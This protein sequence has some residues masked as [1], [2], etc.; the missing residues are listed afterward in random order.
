MLGLAASVANGRGLQLPGRLLEPRPSDGETAR[1]TLGE[2]RDAGG[3]WGVV[4]PDEPSAYLSPVYPVV[5][6]GLIRVFGQQW[7]SP[8]VVFHAILGAATCLLVVRLGRWLVRTPVALAVGWVAAFYPLLVYQS[9]DMWDHCLFTFLLALWV[10]AFF[11]AFWNGG[12][13]RWLTVGALGG[14][15]FLVRP[16]ALPVLVLMLAW[17]WGCG[18]GRRAAS[19]CAVL[20]GFGVAVSPWVLRNW[21][22]M[23][24]PLLFPTKGGRNLWEFN[25]ARF[26]TYFEW[27]EPPKTRQRYRPLRDKYLPTLKRT[28]LVEFPTFTT[29]G[30]IERDAVLQG[31]VK[32]FL[33]ANPRAY[34][35]LCWLRVG[36]FF[37]VVPLHARDTL[38]RVGVAVP[39][40]LALVLGAVG[41]LA[42]A[43]GG[44]LQARF[45]VCLVSLYAA[46]HIFTAAGI[47]Y[48]VPT[49]PYLLLLA[50]YGLSHFGLR[51]QGVV[52][53]TSTGDE[54]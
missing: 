43:R 5:I 7:L 48:R 49:E 2:W 25:N 33:L 32:D 46:V 20:I 47:T 27:S 37:R 13:R 52:A 6:A 35:E 21:H 38:Q 28:D 11:A 18:A 29:E 23:G 44:P 14:V 36:D 8:I 16:V 10:A 39:S 12:L 30:E 40:F 17:M 1:R 51:R 53:G 24:E 26:S 31:R 3:F 34:F 22:V 15:V 54:Q 45:L 42:A 19:T 50:A 9:C 4:R 41:A